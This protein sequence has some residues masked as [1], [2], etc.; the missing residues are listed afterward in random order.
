MT[1]TLP[2]AISTFGGVCLFA[3]GF[4]WYF[5]LFAP[6]TPSDSPVTG[7]PQRIGLLQLIADAVLLSLDQL[8]VFSLFIAARNL[9]YFPQAVETLKQRWRGET[10]IRVCFWIW[11]A[12]W[13][14]FVG[15]VSF[16]I[17]S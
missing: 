4:A 10:S 6:D 12:S 11:M 7:A 1:D 15:G 9:R 16:A 8:P 2:I 13:I 3:F 17:L 14:P 5:P